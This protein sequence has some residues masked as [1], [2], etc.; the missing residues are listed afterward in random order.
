MEKCDT[1]K[2][3]AHFMPRRLEDVTE[4]KAGILVTN[5]LND[6]MKNKQK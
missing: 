2:K 5:N 6:R 3:L 4:S 1:L